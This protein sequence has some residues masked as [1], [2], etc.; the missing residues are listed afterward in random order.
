[1]D[2]G[3]DWR[4]LRAQLADR[5]TDLDGADLDRLADACFWTGDIEASMEHRRAAH[6]AHAAVGD[7]D[8]AGMAAWR[9]FYDHF[10]VG[11]SAIAN[12]WRARGRRHEVD[13]RSRLTGWMALADADLAPDHRAARGHTDRAL[14]LAIAHDDPD[15]RAMA[16]SASGRAALADGDRRV[17]LAH[18]DEAMVA[19]INDELD[20]LYTGW[21]Y[22]GVIGACYAIADLGRAVEWT[23]A[24]MRW[25]TALRDGGL[26][27]G[28]CRVYR[29]EVATM[30][31]DWDLAAHEAQQAC[32]ELERFDERY[33]AEA[34]HLR[35]ELARRRG[36]RDHAAEAFARARE[37]GGD[38]LPGQALLD[39]ADGREADALAALRSAVIQHDAMP[40]PRVRRLRALID[41]AIGAGDALQAT[42]AAE[43]IRAIAQD[44]GSPLLDAHA[45]AASAIT[46]AD[47]TDAEFR[48]AISAFDVV[49]V[50]FESAR[51]R[52]ALAARLDADGDSAGARRERSIGEQVMQRL[53]ATTTSP[54]DTVLTPREREVLRLVADGRTNP[55]IAQSLHLSR[56]T[57]NRHV[58][59]ILT[60]L[61]VNT[62]AAASARAI[63]DGLL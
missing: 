56:H 54:T 15:L 42:H 5:A 14:E 4:A 22:C 46:S 7:D 49:G 31:G 30:R 59:N 21:V 25:S 60:K 28:L 38:P 52:L 44:A 8:A 29:A 26:Y 51:L 47:G 61:E 58:G 12:G 35:G 24:A 13:P 17:G 63:A 6:R 3:T 32:V 23:D 16:L 37:L 10:L 19:V 45:L 33:A 20:P 50:P 41:V 40:L 11:E 18:L 1:M 9:L 55:E 43:A 48:M 2:G 57:V 36:R 39:A 34:H 27:P 53:G 62:R